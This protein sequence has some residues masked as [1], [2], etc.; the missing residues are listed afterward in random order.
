MK[1]TLIGN[2]LKYMC[3]KNYQ[4]RER[5]DK[6]IAKIKGCS[7]LTHMVDRQSFLSQSVTNEEKFVKKF[8]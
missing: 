6:T 2:L 1:Y 8:Y 7:L 3:A 5:F 4:N